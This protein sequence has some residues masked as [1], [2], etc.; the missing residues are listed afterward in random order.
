[1]R[2]VLYFLH[3]F[4]VNSKIT[5]I[6]DFENDNNINNKQV[7]SLLQL[8]DEF[9][10]YIEMSLNKHS[11]ENDRFAL[12]SRDMLIEDGYCRC[13]AR[14]RNLTNKLIININYLTTTNDYETR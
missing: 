4:F 5:S 11:G 1:M 12:M 3:I 8:R 14:Y 9:G 2:V 13:N 7:K 10:R 6:F